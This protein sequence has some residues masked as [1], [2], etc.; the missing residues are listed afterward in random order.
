[1]HLSLKASLI[2][3]SLAL[4]PLSAQ[5]GTHVVFDLGSVAF[6][7][8]DGYWDRDHRWHRWEHRHDWERYRRE[9]REHAYNHRHSHYHD[10][11][12]HDNDRYWDHR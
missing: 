5:A 10:H 6:A 7:Y 8:N 4:L 2:A 11:G 3:L 1:M 9:Y 12:W